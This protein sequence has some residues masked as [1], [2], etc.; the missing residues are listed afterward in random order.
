MELKRGG[1]IYTICT[2]YDYTAPDTLCLI[3][4]RVLRNLGFALFQLAVLL[5]L[6]VGG[7]G[8]P[9]MTLVQFFSSVS[10]LGPT[11]MFIGL[12]IILAYVFC[13]VGW[14]INKTSAAYV[15]RTPAAYRKMCGKVTWK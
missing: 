6:I 1:I 8:F 12:W 5:V 11:G 9:V 3:P 13:F 14:M 2:M 7:I 10:I 15:D 4:L